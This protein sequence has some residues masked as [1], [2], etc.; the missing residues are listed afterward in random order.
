ML[1]PSPNLAASAVIPFVGTQDYVV[2]RD[3]YV[4]LGWQLDWDRGELAQLT[5]GDQKLFLQA[6]YQREWCEN[7]MLHVTV[8]DAV[9]WH[10][11]AQ[12]VIEQGAFGAARVEAPK[13]ESYGALV[14][15][16]WDPAGVLLHMAQPLTG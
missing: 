13:Y 2:S 6:H 1:R 14:T 9:A 7:S 10:R 3:F 4:A 15:Y 5:L 8:S 11:H 16:I 12:A